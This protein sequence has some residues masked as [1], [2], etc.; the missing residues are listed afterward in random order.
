MSLHHFFLDKQIIADESDQVFTLALSSDDFKHAQVLRLKPGEH[1]S[2]VDGDADYF[3]LEIIEV[4]SNAIDVSIAKH[5]EKSSS[6]H[7]PQFVLAQ[8]LAKGDKMDRLIKQCIEVGAQSI[9]PIAMNRS[10]VQLDAK[11]AAKRSER[12]NSI[13]REAAMQSGA[14]QLPQVTPVVSWTEFCKDLTASDMVLV[15]WEEAD[16]N[17][18]MLALIHDKFQELMSSHRCIVVIGPEGGIAPAEIEQLHNSPAQIHEISLGATILRTETAG[19][20]ALAIAKQGL[21]YFAHQNDTQAITS[22]KQVSHE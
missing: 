8:G 10:I 14:R 19:I 7:I 17:E 2:V 11:K 16:Q 12:W 5:S 21:D 13:A 9:I 4:T 20:V 22:E 18:S 15:C 3:E 6:L 1:I